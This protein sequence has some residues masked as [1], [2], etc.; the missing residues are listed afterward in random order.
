MFGYSGGLRV[1]S[2]FVKRSAMFVEAVFKCTSGFSYVLIVTLVTLYHADKV[3]GVAI[4]VM[5][6]FSFN[7]RIK[8]ILSK[9][10]VGSLLRATCDSNFNL[11]LEQTVFHIGILR[12]DCDGK[13]H[14]LCFKEGKRNFPLVVR[15]LKSRNML[16][17]S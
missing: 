9:S 12:V 3:F 5:I 10:V 15:L 7:G 1:V 11:L 2:S 17:A 14:C 16:K 13:Q 6:N 4:N 8:R